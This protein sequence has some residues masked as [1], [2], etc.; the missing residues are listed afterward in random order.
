MNAHGRRK[1][2]FESNHPFRPATDCLQCLD[3][4]GLGDKARESFLHYNAV[5]VFGL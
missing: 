3:D 2:R 5:T 1:V 4:P